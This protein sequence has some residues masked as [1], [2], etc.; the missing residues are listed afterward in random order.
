MERLLLDFLLGETS[1]YLFVLTKNETFRNEQ[2]KEN[3]MTTQFGKFMTISHLL[4]Y[5][6]H[7]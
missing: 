5:N 7:T 6:I 1:L 4:V 2:P 3:V